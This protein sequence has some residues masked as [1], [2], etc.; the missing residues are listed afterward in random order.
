MVFTT[1][2]VPELSACETDDGVL[3]NNS[4][5]WANDGVCDDGGPGARYDVCDLGT[6]CSDCDTRPAE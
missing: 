3:C 4:C 1:S 5:E 6:D 2:C